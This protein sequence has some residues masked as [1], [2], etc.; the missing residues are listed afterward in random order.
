EDR[1]GARPHD[2]AVG[3]RAGGS[4]DRIARAQPAR[5]TPASSSRVRWAPT[6]LVRPRSLGAPVLARLVGWYRAR[7][8]WDAPPRLRPSTDPVRR[9]RVAGHVLHDRDRAFAHERDGYR[10]GAHAVVR[11]AAGGVAGVE[12]GGSGRL[13]G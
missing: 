4:A 2:P 10:M 12:G 3:A 11:D 6:S 9:A 13:G 8:H 5:P 7:G 1:Q